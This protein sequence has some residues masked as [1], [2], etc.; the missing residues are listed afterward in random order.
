METIN[1]LEVQLYLLP[2]R[3]IYLESSNSLLVADLHLGKSATFQAYGIPIP[4]CTTDL[5]LKRLKDLCTQIQPEN[6]YILG[7]LFHSRLALQDGTLTTWIDFLKQLAVPTWLIVGNHDRSLVKGLEQHHL[8]ILLDR[9]HLGNLVLSHEPIIPSKRLNLCGH[10]HPCLRLK[11][12]LDDL[13][14]PC[15]YFNVARKLL[16]L[17]SFGE[18]TGGWDVKL[19]P[20]IIAYGIA[21]HKIIPFAG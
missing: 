21:D 1:W 15:F 8:N 14:L 2:E 7:D 20:D 3:A 5:T 13:R 16:V 18:F 4:N 10:I 19:E 9:I 17:P 12:R 6:L 11:S